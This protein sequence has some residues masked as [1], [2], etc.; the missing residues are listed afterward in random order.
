MMRSRHGR[1]FVPFVEQL[2][3]R[4]LLDASGL[5][6]ADLAGSAEAEG[7]AAPDFGLVDVNP[8]SPM[9][10]QTVSPRDYL[11]EVSVWMFGFSA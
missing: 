1:H 3:S 5:P 8:A 7:E 9:Y 4:L 11:G 10:N 2:E 6:L